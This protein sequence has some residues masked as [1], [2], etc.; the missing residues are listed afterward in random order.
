MMFLKR[1]HLKNYRRYHDEDIEFPTGLI[2]IVGRNGSG[3][4]SL[5]EAVG[6]CL[7]GNSASRTKKDQIKT[8]GIPETEDCS[9]TLEIMLGADTVKI[10]REL[11]GKNASGYASIFVNGNANAE[12]RGM[13]EVSEFIAK[14]TGMDHVA[15]FTSVFAKQKELDSLSNLQPGERKKT[16]MRLLRI[17]KIDDAITAIRRD[18]RVSVDKISFLQSNLKDIDSLEKQSSKISEE[19]EETT[20]QIQEHDSKIKMLLAEVQ[21][22]KIEFTIH[23]KKYRSY[24]KVGKDLAKTIEQKNSKIEEKEII[25]SDLKTANV[26]KKKMNQIAP[27]VKQY[28]TV[29]KEKDKFDSLYGKFK[30]K[31]G[32]EEQYSAI[33]PKIRKQEI[34]NKRI[35]K[36]LVKLKGL[37][38]ELKKQDKELEKQEANKES[39]NKS[40]SV[41]STKIKDN[42]ARTSELEEE[43]HTIKKL[44][45]D[46]ECPT[47]KRPLKD[48]FP[49]VSE[50]FSKEISK[51]SDKIN[52]DYEKKKKL[53][54]ELKS[55]KKKIAELDVY[56]DE[57]ERMKTERI[58][59]QTQLK[60]GKKVIATMSRDKTNLVKK[61]KKFSGLKYNRK[62]HLTI[63]KQY[64]QLSK[65][66]DESMKLFADLKRIPILLNRKK[67]SID[68][69]SK[70]DKE[71]SI[72]TKNLDSIGYSESEY[73]KS[74][75]SL[76][77]SKENHTK[78]REKWIELKGEITNLIFQIK[79]IAEDIEEEKEK[80]ITIDKENEKIGSRSKLEKIMNEF[81]LDL[82]SRIRPILS[83]R[84]SELFRKITKGKYP[85]MDL[86]EDYNIRIEDEGNSFTTDRFSGGE[87]DLANL[88][89]R[90]AIS[91]ELSERA[92]GMQANFIA[93]DEIFGSQDEGRKNNILEALSELSNQFKQIIIITHVEDVKEMLPY[94]LTVKENSDNTIKIETEGIASVAMI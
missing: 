5:I 4:S 44:G 85:S 84:A 48:H 23:E 43:F 55:V 6:W 62:H 86:D 50:Y 27:K 65:I 90:I 45:N 87:E 72:E 25:E 68:I 24:N 66:K 37:D 12:V 79:Q 31:E 75:E 7:Y 41:I 36:N 20:K 19:K 34:V 63:N 77:E 35:E 30:E 52:A 13:N 28:E 78:T 81:R 61:L 67:Q 73:E 64:G 94:V 11:K 14:R 51:L 54:L 57:F 60:G 80:Q 69:I 17:N 71:E 2:G 74:K 88:C 10:I 92:G 47:C 40:I 1:I 33:S 38:Q 59:I 29:K 49:H 18:V 76:E 39:I 91:Q 26:S 15:F 32:L 70:L 89:L 46:G 9:V 8:T 22:R 42:C 58:S 93:L 3:K 82:I 21:K 56:I 16:I 83:Q 53:D